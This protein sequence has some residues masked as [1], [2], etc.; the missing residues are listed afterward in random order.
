MQTVKCQNFFKH[1]LSLTK[2]LC[3]AGITLEEDGLLIIERVKKDDE[4]LYE[5]IA[6]NTEGIAKT[7]AAVRVFGKS[8]RYLEILKT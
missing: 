6:K 4:G 8:L 3:A 5:C 2:R 7:S 1:V